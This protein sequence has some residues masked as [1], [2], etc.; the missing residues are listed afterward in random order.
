MTADTEPG[1]LGELPAPAHR[2]GQTGAV[3]S[4]NLAQ[5]TQ[6]SLRGQL[7]QTGIRKVPNPDRIRV[8][9]AGLEGDIQAD[10][11]VH[12]GTSKAVYGYSAPDYRW[13]S[14][15]LG[16]DLEPGR[17]GENLTID[18]LSATGA[19]IGERWRV[20][21]A[22]LEVTQPR[23]PCWKLGARMGDP[24]FPR[25]FRAAGRPGLYFAV[26]EPGAVATG[27]PIEV[28]HLPTHPITIGLIGH[29]NTADRELA[30][31][32]MQLCR[33]DLSAQEWRQLLSASPR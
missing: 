14:E 8:T 10:P 16:E 9:D 30:R 24:G 15:Q 19:L 13:W 17:F 26:L 29:L 18:G 23:E 2:L 3:T 5:V 31:M 27:D 25:R 32:L 22:V 11:S 28:T 12:G 7:H 20:G 1:S 4:V 33:Q 6:L 21:S